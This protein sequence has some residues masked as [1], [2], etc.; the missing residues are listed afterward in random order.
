MLRIKTLVPPLR[1]LL[2]SAVVI[3]G[4]ASVQA[5]SPAQI[6]E[7]RRLFEREWT[8]SNPVFGG[9]GLG[10]LFN[11]KS[12]VACH[13]QGGVGGGGDA[14]FNARTVGIVEMQV[15]PG[16][17]PEVLADLVSTFHPGFVADG[18]VISAM[19]LHHHG[20]TS[21]FQNR[22][23]A[24]LN[25]LPSLSDAAGGPRDAAEV[26][27]EIRIPLDHQQTLGRYE[28]KMRAQIFHR[29][30]TPLFGAG[31][32]DAVPVEEMQQQAQL[33]QRHAE[34]SG[35]VATLTNGK[36][37]KFG[38]RGN[39]A[40]LREFNDQACANE[41]GLKTP[42]NDQPTDATAPDYRN[43][44]Q[45]LD[46]KQVEVMHQF[47]AALPAP[48][49]EIKPEVREQVELGEQVFAA[50]G[51]AVCHTPN[52]GPAQ[53]I[54]S[55][56]LLHDMGPALSD[57]NGAEP[58]IVRS[59]VVSQS[60][61]SLTA[62]VTRQQDGSGHYG[63]A[64]RVVLTRGSGSRGGIPMGR[65]G[66]GRPIPLQ[67]PGSQLRSGAQGSTA[68]IAAPT[69]IMPSMPP[70][71]GSASTIT[72]PRILRGPVNF[73]ARS[74]PV[75]RF[76]L[77]PLT[78][79][80]EWDSETEEQPSE[81][82]GKRKVRRFTKTRHD[83]FLQHKIEPTMVTQ[84]WRTPPLWGLQDSPPYMHDGRASTVL[85]AI[86]LHGGEASGTRDRFLSLSLERRDALLAFLDTLVA[87]PGAPQPSD[88]ELAEH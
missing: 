85:E 24:L 21:L 78:S 32:I 53:G 12:C 4:M 25:Q 55:D 88:A 60:S 73:S 46:A 82:D 7:G 67:S 41:L 45:D 44:T 81:A 14:R 3:A 47:V 31:L 18:S 42:T 26:R 5:K 80:E 64:S 63:N 49:R 68:A 29:N 38:W 37:G 16:P 51:C 13:H 56:L 71:Y 52:L 58:R 22:R 69:A 2:S 61:G 34:I 77:V 84:E 1:V 87:P 66:S 35:R 20:G 50:V 70:Y 23:A 43:P 74:T 30:T 62:A 59:K 76:Q 39:V 28:L 15:E 79:V 19:P 36:V 83:L 40:S 65:S 27:R 9:D 72:P 33:Q 86:T 17:P 6:E 48:V 75:R 8:A 10:P 57:P 11:G 54:Y